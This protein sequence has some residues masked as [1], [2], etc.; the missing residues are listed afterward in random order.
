VWSQPRTI[1]A[2]VSNWYNSSFEEIWHS[3]DA[4]RTENR[5]GLLYWK[6]LLML[7]RSAVDARS[8]LSPLDICWLSWLKLWRKQGSYHDINRFI[9]ASLWCQPLNCRTSAR[10]TLFAFTTSRKWNYYDSGKARTFRK[11]SFY[12]SKLNLSSRSKHRPKWPNIYREIPR[13]IIRCS[14]SS[15]P[16][17]TYRG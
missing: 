3:T 9:P 8:K 7:K 6:G 5:S 15:C 1:K 12:C 16:I 4:P 11:A 2:H 10:R 13:E 14:L 17:R